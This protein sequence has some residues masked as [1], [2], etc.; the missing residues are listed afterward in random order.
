M[1]ILFGLVVV[2]TIL[3]MRKNIEF[4]EY[5]EEVAKLADEAETKNAVQSIADNEYN[6][7]IRKCQGGAHITE[8]N[9]I[10]TILKTKY[11]YVK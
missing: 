9:R 5:A 3:S 11:K 2:V 1:T 7:L 4:W 6:E 10:S 8:V